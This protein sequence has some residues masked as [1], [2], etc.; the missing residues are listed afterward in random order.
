M[1]K[2]RP[3]P[4]WR[5]ERKCWFVQIGKRQIKLSPDEAEAWRLYHELMAK[6]AEAPRQAQVTGPSALVVEVLDAFLE[7]TKTNQAPK[8]YRW[9]RDHIQNFVR[10][11][12]RD[13]DRRGTEALPRHPRHGFAG[14]LVGEHQERLCA[15]PSSAA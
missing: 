12:P 4:F 15:V 11:H 2:K 10:G 5:A 6:P 9:H 8:T 14:H 1:P 7:W 3:E 13:A